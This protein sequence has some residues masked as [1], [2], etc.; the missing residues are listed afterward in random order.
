MFNEKITES[1]TAR[2]NE[3]ISAWYQEK[4][5]ALAKFFVRT[6]EPQKELISLKNTRCFAEGNSIES[7]LKQ[8][9]VAK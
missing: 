9:L 3:D 6:A 7:A 4:V 5:T 2:S 8:E 1:F